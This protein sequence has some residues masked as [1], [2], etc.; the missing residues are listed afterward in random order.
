MIAPHRQ[1]ATMEPSKALE[2][3][4]KFTEMAIEA[5]FRELVRECI[6]LTAT[7]YYYEDETAETDNP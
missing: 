6:A 3:L 7:G 2:Q 4:D 5:H 1:N